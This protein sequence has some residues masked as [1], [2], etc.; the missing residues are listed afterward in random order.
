MRRRAVAALAVSLAS[1]GP[2]TFPGG[3]LEG[4]PRVARAPAAEAERALLSAQRDRIAAGEAAREAAGE[5][6]EAKAARDRAL[7]GHGDA[8][9]ERT[10]VAY[11]ERVL[12]LRS[13]AAATA[14]RRI[15][16]ARA[17]HELAKATVAYGHSVPEADGLDVETFSAEVVRAGDEVAAAEKDEAAL[18]AQ[19]AIL[20]KAV[21]TARVAKLRGGA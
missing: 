11:L 17:R 6:R 12:A 4:L 16:L 1:C 2:P 18:G 20:K 7:A 14:D 10:N 9:F 5:L 15:D 8:D 21:H 3:A 19:V 13:A